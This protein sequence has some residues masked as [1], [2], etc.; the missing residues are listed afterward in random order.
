MKR[1][2]ELGFGDLN[3]AA[4]GAFMRHG[5]VSAATW[6]RELWQKHRNNLPPA[7]DGT[8]TPPAEATWK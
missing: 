7:A 1:A 4:P 3:K 8:K 2:I 6:V 5:F